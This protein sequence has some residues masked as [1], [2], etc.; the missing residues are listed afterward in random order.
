MKSFVLHWE[1]E[2]EL[3]EAI[4]YY[5]QRRRGLGGDLRR[6]FAA[7]V[8]RIR[9]NPRGFRKDEDGLRHALLRTFPYAVI[10]FELDDRLWITAVAHHSRR[11]GYWLHRHPDDL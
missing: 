8:K 10:F 7:T 2:A 6:D 4:V 9:I 3:E 5:N 1:A 11:P